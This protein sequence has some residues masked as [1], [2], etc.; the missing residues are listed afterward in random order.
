MDNELP[1]DLSHCINLFISEL[2]SKKINYYGD[3]SDFGNEVGYALG[4]TIENMSNTQIRDFI[5]GLRH[6]I[7]LTNGTH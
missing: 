6:G 5:S 7:S 4:K 1:H 2:G 3:I